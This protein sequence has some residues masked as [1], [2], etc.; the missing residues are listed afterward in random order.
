MPSSTEALLSRATSSVSIE[1]VR[2]HSVL[3]DDLSFSS[4]WFESKDNVESESDDAE[5]RSETL[6]ASRLE[7]VSTS[8]P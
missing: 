5:E 6:P 2:V 8:S 7:M 1:S 4:M 3:K